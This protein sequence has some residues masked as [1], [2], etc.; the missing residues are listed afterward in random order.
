MCLDYLARVQYWQP[1]VIPRLLRVQNHTGR[2]FELVEDDFS[3]S[4]P[5]KNKILQKDNLCKRCMIVDSTKLLLKKLLL[6]EFVYTIASLVWQIT[7]LD[8]TVASLQ[9]SLLLSLK[10]TWTSVIKETCPLG[11]REALDI[12]LGLRSPFLTDRGFIRFS[13]CPRE[14][15]RNVLRAP[16]SS[17]YLIFITLYSLHCIHY[18]AFIS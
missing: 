10:P 17:T 9:S 13:K 7:E 11:F 4:P 15:L 2:L 6:S 16:A 1:Q 18:T 5:R 12:F 14:P 8:Y 3:G